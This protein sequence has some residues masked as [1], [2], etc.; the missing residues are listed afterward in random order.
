MEKDTNGTKCNRYIYQFVRFKD[1]K[2]PLILI[3]KV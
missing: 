2:N 3:E 1:F